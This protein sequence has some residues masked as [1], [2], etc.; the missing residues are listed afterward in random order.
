MDRVQLLM[1]GL[2]WSLVKV[3]HVEFSY[4]RAGLNSASINKLQ[5]LFLQ[6][7][8]LLQKAK[9]IS[10]QQRQSKAALEAVMACISL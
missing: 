8:A 1:S 10:Q 2:N 6:L 5:H 9:H 7:N 4:E 3:C